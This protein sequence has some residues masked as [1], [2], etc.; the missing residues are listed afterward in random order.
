MDEDRGYHVMD[1]REKNGVAE[2]DKNQIKA[3]YPLNSG[4]PTYEITIRRITN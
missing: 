4:E 1:I 3:K 2:I